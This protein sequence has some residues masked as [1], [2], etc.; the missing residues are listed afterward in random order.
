M[1]ITVLDTAADPERHSSAVSSEAGAE[2]VADVAEFAVGAV[3]RSA[4]AV[5]APA[6]GAVVQSAFGVVAPAVAAVARSAAAVAA[7]A[8]GAV[9]QSAFGVV[10][11]A[12]AAAA[13]SVSAVAAPTAVVAVVQAGADAAAPVAASAAQ[14]VSGVVVAPT[15]RPSRGRPWGGSGFWAKV[16]LALAEAADPAALIGA[17]RAT[18]LRLEECLF[19]P[20]AFAPSAAAALSGTFPVV[21]SW[22]GWVVQGQQEERSAMV[23]PSFL[24]GAVLAERGRLAASVGWAV[25]SAETGLPFGLPKVAAPDR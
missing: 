4:A 8:V 21:W 15:A 14:S 11:P 6:V 22:A 7:P 1:G 12:V 18:A 17:D 20:A 23:R 13:R 25:G 10:A 2:V 5:A 24:A 3:V 16:G 19:S 9:V